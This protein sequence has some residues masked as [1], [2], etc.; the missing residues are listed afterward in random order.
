MAV[1]YED[2]IVDAI[3]DKSNVKCTPILLS[4]PLEYA[5]KTN[6]NVDRKRKGFQSSKGNTENEL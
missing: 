6:N 2:L 5:K 4:L 1:V 3:I